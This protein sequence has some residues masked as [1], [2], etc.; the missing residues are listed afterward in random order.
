M[1]KISHKRPD[2]G[3]RFVL[4]VGGVA[5]LLVAV[6]LCRGV[7]AGLMLRIGI[8]ALQVR[9]PIADIAAQFKSKAGLERD[10]AQLRAALA[11]TSATLA[12]RQLLYED[13]LQLKAR[14]GRDIALRTVLAGIV[15]RP[16]GV[17]YDTLLID[18]GR[19]QGVT[20]G[21]NVSAGGTTRIGSV[22]EVYA[23]GAR[24]KLFSSP[25]ESYQ[26]LL[27]ETEAHPAIPVT[28]VGQG[29]S[30]MTAQI[31]AKTTVVPGDA[32]VLPGI[33]G[34]YTAV[35]SHVDVRAGES[36]EIVYL[37]LPVNFQQLRYVEVLLR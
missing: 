21:A 37:Q 23:T 17:P 16:P 31:P 29:G 15:M 7:F 2:T 24:V 22:D 28:V 19:Q 12:D 27:S 9:N 30:S 4:I 35:V 26:G 3:W 8:P 33:A 5:L 6:L 20:M 1:R 10:N 11:S 18:A 14:L 25:G 32:V 36:F 34:G 13:N